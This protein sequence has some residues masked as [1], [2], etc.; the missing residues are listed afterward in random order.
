MQ[1]CLRYNNKDAPTRANTISSIF[2]VGLTGCA[3]SVLFVIS[4]GPVYRLDMTPASNSKP[5][6]AYPID[7]ESL[8]DQARLCCACS[9][10]VPS[11]KIEFSACAFVVEL[12]YIKKDTY[13]V[14]YI[15]YYCMSEHGRPQPTDSTVVIRSQQL[16]ATANHRIHKAFTW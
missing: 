5:S 4:H 6:L 11:L 15:N 14:L 3:V 1:D 7:T 16:N 10:L 9:E 12:S 8:R 2:H 13:Y